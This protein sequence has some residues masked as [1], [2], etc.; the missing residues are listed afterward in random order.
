MWILQAII[1]SRF[2]GQGRNCKGHFTALSHFQ[3]KSGTRSAERWTADSRSCKRMQAMP[4][5][6]LPLFTA[7]LTEGAV[8][9]PGISNDGASFLENRAITGKFKQH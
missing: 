9:T 3:S 6:F 5:T 4:V 2:G 8:L 1:S 7:D